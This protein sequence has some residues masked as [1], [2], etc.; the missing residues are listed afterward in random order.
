MT[1]VGAG[2]VVTKNLPG[3]VVGFGIPATIRH[4]D[5]GPSVRGSVGHA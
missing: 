1:I 5:V 2:A 4:Q 3:G